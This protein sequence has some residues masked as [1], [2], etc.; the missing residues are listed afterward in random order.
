MQCGGLKEPTKFY[1]IDAETSYRAL[2]SRPWLHSN[3]VVLSILYQCLKYIDNDKQKRIDGDIKPFD[4][5]E[6]KFNNTK[7]FLPQYAITPV[8]IAKETTKKPL[9]MNYEDIRSS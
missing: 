4:V 9:V 5:Y 2:L 1:I 6:I 8:Q 3:Q 7:Y